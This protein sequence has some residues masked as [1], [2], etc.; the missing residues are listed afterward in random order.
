MVVK[1]GN[2][3]LCARWNIAVHKPAAT[4]EIGNKAFKRLADNPSLPC[5]TMPWLLVKYSDTRICDNEVTFHSACHVVA[6][7]PSV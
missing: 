4:S 5:T 7:R 2:V 1:L 6:T 3:D